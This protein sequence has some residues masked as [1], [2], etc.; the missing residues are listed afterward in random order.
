MSS[1]PAELRA[2]IEKTPAVVLGRK[3][4]FVEDEVDALVG[5]ESNVPSSVLVGGLFELLCSGS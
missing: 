4:R 1:K 2:E 3:N 5:V